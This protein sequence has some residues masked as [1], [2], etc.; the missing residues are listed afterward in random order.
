MRWGWKAA[1][2]LAGAAGAIM[3]RSAG[4][5]IYAETRIGKDLAEAHCLSCH[6]AGTGDA[7]A[8]HGRR[9]TL[10]QLAPR[11]EADPDR[12]RLFLTN[13]HHEMTGISLDRSEIDAIIAYILSLQAPP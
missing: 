8:W 2:L 12:Y 5:E 6:V 11:I 13:P 9:P 1:G 7:A 3:G 10:L 4:A